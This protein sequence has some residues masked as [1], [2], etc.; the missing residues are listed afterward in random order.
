MNLIVVLWLNLFWV[1]YVVNF[2]LYKEYL[3]LCFFII[4]WFLNNF[5]CIVFVIFFCVFCKN[6]WSVCFKGENYKL[7]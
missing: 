7:L 6:V 4:V 2:L 5:I 3:D 1:V